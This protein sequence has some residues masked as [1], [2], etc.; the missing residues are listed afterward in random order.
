MGSEDFEIL[1]IAIGTAP[2]LIVIFMLAAAL[3]AIASIFAGRALARLQFAGKNAQIDNLKSQIASKNGL[4]ELVLGRVLSVKDDLDRANR[5]IKTLESQIAARASY[6]EL[7]E[8]LAALGTRM[9]GIAGSNSTTAEILGPD[10]KL[11]TGKNQAIA[12]RRDPTFD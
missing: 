9:S 3:I 12:T 5:L 8:T 1:W 4:L 10:Y 6:S 11:Y 2:G 7:A